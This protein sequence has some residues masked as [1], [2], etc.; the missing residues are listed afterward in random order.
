VIRASSGV[1]LYAA[2]HNNSLEAWFAHLPG[3]LVV[4]PSSPADT[5]GLLKSALRGEDPVL[6]MMHKRLTGARGEVGGPEDLVPIGKAA[7]VRE[8]GDVTLVAAGAVVGRAVEAAAALAGEG[9]EAEVIDLRTIFPLDLELVGASARKTG[10]IVV[11]SEEPVYAS[12]ASELAASI[13]EAAFE[14]LD[15]PVARV[16][17]AHSPIPHSPPLI[18]ALIP[19]PD[20]VVEAVRSSFRR[21]PRAEEQLAAA[22]APWPRP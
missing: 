6:F 7:V 16:A 14:Y 20:D 9:V 4:M 21:W 13:Q 15:A 19:Q 5:K 10:R 11:V 3:L 8:G 22:G 12:V 2:Q 17:A 18:D 1:G